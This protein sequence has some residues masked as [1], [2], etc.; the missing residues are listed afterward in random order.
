MLVSFL[1]TNRIG[2]GA[3]NCQLPGDG[4]A[5]LGSLAGF[6]IGNAGTESERAFL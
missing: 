4:A 2:C 1:Q 3:A 5:L 6:G